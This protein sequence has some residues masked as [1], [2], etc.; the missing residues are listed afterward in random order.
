MLLH[1]ARHALFQ[2]SIVKNKQE[3]NAEDIEFCRQILV[4][5]DI[6][7]ANPY[8]AFGFDPKLVD[9]RCHGTT[10]RSPGCPG[11]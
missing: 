5:I 11:K 7:F 2:I 3:R 4:G 9:N 10:A 1:A 8:F 6:Q